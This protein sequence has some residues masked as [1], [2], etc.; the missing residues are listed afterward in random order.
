MSTGNDERHECRGGSDRA[1]V[2]ESWLKGRSLIRGSDDHS[3]CLHPALEGDS[4]DLVQG[5]V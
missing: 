5:I 3:P 4:D 2:A 1:M